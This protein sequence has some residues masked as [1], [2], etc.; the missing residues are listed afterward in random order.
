MDGGILALILAGAGLLGGAIGWLSSQYWQRWQAK[1]QA[2]GDASKILSDKKKLLEEMISGTEDESHKEE[3][4]LQL[5][6]VNTALLGLHSERLRRT[7]KDAG[8]PPEEALVADGLSQLQPEQVNELKEEIKEVE[9][10]PQSESIW[11]LLA[12]ANAY[13]YSGQYKDAKHVYDKI[14]IS[15]PDDYTILSNRGVTYAKL[16]KHNEAL[17]DLNRA[18]EL[19][20]DDPDTLNNRGNT[21]DNLERY[22]E[23]LADYNRAL[24]LRPDDPDTLNNRGNTYDN[25]ERYDEA[26]ADYNRAL[27]LRPDDPDT[28]TNRGATYGKLKKYDE[29]LADFNRSLELRPDD[30][31]TLTNRGATYGKLKKYDEALTE[32]NRSLELEPDHPG[33]LYDL[34]CLFSLWGKTKDA[35]DYLKKAVDKDEEWREDAKTDEDFDN[36]RDD[37]RFK[38][39]VGE[40]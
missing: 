34:A 26:L 5:D 24:E 27:E 19:R 32:L 35:L 2:A 12:L 3:L 25:L 14:L 30:P 13:Y 36:I 10:L 39:L 23:A 15:N 31:D 17:A 1:R 22:D 21:Y 4:R 40:D 8:L 6:E 29:A 33:T 7:L 28:F 9:S 37:P 20:P 16:G 11:D 18:L 38:K